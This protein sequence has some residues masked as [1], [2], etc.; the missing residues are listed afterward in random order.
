MGFG[1]YLMELVL[2]EKNAS[3]S[4]FSFYTKSIK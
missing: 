2:L 1:H 3:F 4:H